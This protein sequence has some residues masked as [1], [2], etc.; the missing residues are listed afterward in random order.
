MGHRADERI[1]TLD[2]SVRSYNCLLRAG[3]DTVNKVIGAVETNNIRNCRN[4][5]RKSYREILE[6]LNGKGYG[7]FRDRWTE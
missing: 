3:W 4:L 1:E 2:L 6:R 5:G 7:P